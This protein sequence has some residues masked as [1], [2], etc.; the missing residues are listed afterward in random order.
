M[1]TTKYTYA[2]T[3]PA[4]LSTVL[5]AKKNTI[6]TSANSIEAGYK[7]APKRVSKNNPRHAAQAGAAS[8]HTKK[9]KWGLPPRGG[10][11]AMQPRVHEVSKQGNNEI[12]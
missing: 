12:K 11:G 7:V 1:Q 2:N 5:G 6:C 9:P 4:P 8:T 3:C 10:P